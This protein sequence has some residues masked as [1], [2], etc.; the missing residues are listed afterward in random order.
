M[1]LLQRFRAKTF[2]G[3]I[4][5]I[6]GLGMVMPTF[7]FADGSVNANPDELITLAVLDFKNTTGRF[8]LDRLEK[9]LPE[10]L[11]TELSQTDKIIVVER[12]RLEAIMNEQALVLSGVIDEQAALK[13]GQFLG[14]QYIITGEITYSGRKL[15]IDSHI[16]KT[17]TGQVIGEK[18]IGSD[19]EVLD[20]MI[21]VLATNII[22][23]LTGTG[24]K[25]TKVTFGKLP[26]NWFLG[27]TAVSALGLGLTH[28]TY[29]KYYDDYKAA[30]RL[31]DID[32]NYSNANR[33]RKSRDLLI[34]A[35]TA[36][37]ITTFVLWLVSTS[38]RNE[39]L[40]MGEDAD[41][42]KD[43]QKLLVD[44]QVN[45]CMVSFNLCY[46]F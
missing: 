8:H 33:Y 25:V 20:K 32:S 21:Q 43:R 37:G 38:N 4:I 41:Y 29:K 40:A 44:V 3:A 17:E 5:G 19:T 13:V 22:Y 14:A 2:R 30:N 35:T 16:Q 45:P 31:D 6:I 1:H 12:Q 10:M 24:E 28:S 34:G 11:K 39:I 15:R 36:L 26:T 18:V 23:N 7:V 42:L 9:T 46:Q 27:A